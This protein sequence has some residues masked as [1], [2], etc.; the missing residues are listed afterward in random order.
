MWCTCWQCCPRGTA[1]RQTYSSFTWTQKWKSINNLNFSEENFSPLMN[2]QAWL[3]LNLKIEFSVCF[4]PALGAWQTQ[5]PSDMSQRETYC[6]KKVRGEVGGWEGKKTKKWADTN[7]KRSPV[8]WEGGTLKIGKKTCSCK[9]DLLCD[10]RDK[11]SLSFWWGKF[12]NVYI[13]ICFYK[14]LKMGSD[15]SA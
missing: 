9:T 6:L 2:I 12:H 1:V 10:Y 4:F 5:A 3:Q 15:H 14:W 8:P 7:Q 13:F 11:L